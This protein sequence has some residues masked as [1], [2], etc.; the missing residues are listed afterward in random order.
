MRR[1]NAFL[2][3]YW[4]LA[5][6]DRRLEVTHLQ[7]GEL[8]RSASLS[9]VLAWVRDHADDADDTLEEL[10]AEEEAPPGYT[11]PP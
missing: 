1:Y 9:E 2:L 6:A 11:R 8:M 5:E 4:A 10:P 7:S 3:R